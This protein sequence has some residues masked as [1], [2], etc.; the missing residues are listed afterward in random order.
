MEK[1]TK[2]KIFFFRLVVFAIYANR[3]TY[4]R[5]QIKSY[6]E[7]LLLL[8]GFL[9][10]YWLPNILFRTKKK[11]KDYDGVLECR[12]EENGDKQYKFSV[13]IETLDNKK[14]LL[15]KV[16]DKED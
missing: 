9:I 10:C 2:I 16:K 8:F 5:V 13:N 12:T 7:A 15:I 4:E 6:G 1:V 11:D 3:L 14:E